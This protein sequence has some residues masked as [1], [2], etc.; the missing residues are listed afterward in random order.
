MIF[1][2]YENYKYII[3][4]YLSNRKKIY[5]ENKQKFMTG[6]NPTRLQENI[7]SNRPTLS[8][9]VFNG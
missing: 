9:H 8:D 3:G 5:N 6:R 4:R 7:P 1:V 2:C